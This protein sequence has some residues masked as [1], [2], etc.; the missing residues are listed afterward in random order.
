MDW[1]SVLFGW[2]SRKPPED[3]G[4]AAAAASHAEGGENENI[5]AASTAPESHPGSSQQ[6]RWLFS[7]GL[8]HWNQR[9]RD[10]AF[11][12]NFAGVNFTKEAPKTRLWGRPIDL[13][14][15]ERAVLTGVDFAHADLQGCILTKADLRG[16]KLMGAN[17]R[18]ANLAGANLTG[19]DLTDCDLRGA[20]LDG[21][22]FAR[23]KLAHANMSGASMKGTNFAWADLSHAIVGA[24]NLQD[25][26]VF[27]AL[28]ETIKHSETH[29]LHPA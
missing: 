10:G 4:A 3:K 17:L 7:E 21:A 2:P 20:T 28:R 27:G 6:H 25:A 16:A 18:N 14:G 9:R 1:R 26:H 19:A 11:V 5:Y 24:R 22:Q 8:L 12:P 29:Q 23:A 13:V 15:D